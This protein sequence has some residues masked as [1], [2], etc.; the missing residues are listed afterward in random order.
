[1]GTS[2]SNK[3]GSGGAW[4]GF[5]RSATDFAKYGGRQR[6]GKALAGYVA[7]MG[8]AAAAAAAATAGSR[9]GQSLGNFLAASTGPNGL[10]DGLEAVGLGHLVGQDRY[11][12]LSE[13]LNAFAG[14]GSDIETQAA[15]NAL[16]DVLDELLPEEEGTE[17]NSVQL[18]EQAVTE[19]LCRY[20]DALVYNLAIP[21]IDERLTRLENPALAQE[22]D[23]DLRDYIDALVRLR[24]QDTSPLQIDWHGA[25]GQK[26][27]SDILRAVYDQLEEWG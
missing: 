23:R 18:D 10:A 8:G 26:F 6:A 13:L 4:T 1:M 12:V 20:L 2:S 19:S 9:T 25:E 22:R 5:K 16:L 17:L 14:D 24:V 7:A 27:I 15:R 21:I 3:G 11:S